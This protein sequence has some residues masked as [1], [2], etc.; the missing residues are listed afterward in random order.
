M[1]C[2]GLL[3]GGLRKSRYLRVLLRY[4]GR[5]LRKFRGHRGLLQVYLRCGYGAHTVRIR[6]GKGVGGGLISGSV[7]P[8]SLRVGSG[9]ASTGEALSRETWASLEPVSRLQ[10]DDTE[11]KRN[12]VGT[13]Q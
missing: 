13:V 11:L 5:H 4:S 6:C 7:N 10:G 3:G 12:C 9:S 8:K 1:E 2:L